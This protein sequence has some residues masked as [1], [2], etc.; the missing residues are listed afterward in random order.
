[1]K[2]GLFFGS[3]NPVHTGHMIIANYIL[4]CSELDKIWLVLSPQNPFKKK[5]TLA[6]DFD[7]LHLLYLATEDNPKILPSSVEFDM[8]KPSYTIDTLAFLGE[9][10]PDHIFSL[11]M[12]SDN[13]N[14]LR[15]WKNGDRIIENYQIYVYR[16]SDQGDGELAVH[17]NVQLVNA[18][19]LDISASF[20][21]NMIRNNMSIEYLVP[22]NVYQYLAGSNMY[23]I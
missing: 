13:L 14:G 20:I 22:Q 23:K 7:R 21:R 19:L 4:Q 17:P 15:K 8:P 6:R 12:G 9:K 16:R 1:M 5:E 2:V 11:I 18:P 10:F 3:F